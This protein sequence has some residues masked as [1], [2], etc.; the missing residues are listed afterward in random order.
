MVE[1]YSFFVVPETSIGNL[2]LRTRLVTEMALAE[3]NLR[4]AY[5]V[6]RRKTFL[7][8]PD[9]A[10]NQLYNLVK[11]KDASGVHA[12]LEKLSKKFNYDVTRCVWIIR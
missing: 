5:H 9:R 2:V 11:G 12:T 7:S 8:N 3:H 1:K 6:E 4:V 10:Y